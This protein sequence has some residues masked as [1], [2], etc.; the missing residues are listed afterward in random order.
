MRTYPKI[1]Q[2]FLFV[3]NLFYI[4]LKLFEHIQYIGGAIFFQCFSELIV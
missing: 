2:V 3:V 4:F 1:K